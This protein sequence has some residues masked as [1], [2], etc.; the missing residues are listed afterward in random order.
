MAALQES[1]EALRY[2]TQALPNFFSSVIGREESITDSFSLVDSTQWIILQDVVDSFSQT[3]MLYELIGDNIYA[4]M[5][6][7]K[8]L[9]IAR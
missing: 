9:E 3:G 6:F 2:R 7:K 8:G 5:Y 1:L 4:E